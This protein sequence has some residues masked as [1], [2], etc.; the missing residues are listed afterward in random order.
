M[1]NLVD[2]PGELKFSELPLLNPWYGKSK[3]LKI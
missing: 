3:I 1:T 2:A